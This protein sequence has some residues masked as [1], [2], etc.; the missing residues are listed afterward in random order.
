MAKKPQRRKDTNQIA[1]TIV[2]IATG[3]EPKQQDKQPA[4]KKQDK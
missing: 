2:E 1:E 3:N 4:T